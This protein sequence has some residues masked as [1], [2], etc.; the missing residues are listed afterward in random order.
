[1]DRA[2]RLVLCLV[3]GLTACAEDRWKEL[4]RHFESA[5]AEGHFSGNVLIAEGDEVV[6]E[7][8]YGY[9]V[10][11]FGIPMGSDTRFKLHSLTKPITSVAVMT[12]VREGKLGLEDSVCQYLDVCADGWKEA[13]VRQLLNHTSGIPDFANLLVDGWEAFPMFCP[14]LFR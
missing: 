1:M 9:A 3:F 5:L 10:E 7:N 13:T 4:D 12:A 2:C 14:R 6:F 8:S 11:E